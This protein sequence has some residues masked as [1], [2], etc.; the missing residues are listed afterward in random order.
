MTCCTLLASISPSQA[1]SCMSIA[2]S[3][4]QTSCQQVI[5][6]LPATLSMFCH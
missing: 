3:N 2:Q 5:A 4:N 6:T 1:A